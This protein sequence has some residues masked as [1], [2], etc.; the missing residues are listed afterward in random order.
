MMSGM[1]NPRGRPKETFAAYRRLMP[2]ASAV[3]VRERAIT[4]A[5]FRR[6]SLEFAR[7]ITGGHAFLYRFDWPAPALGGALRAIHGVDIPCLF[8]TFDAMAGLV[9]P[10]SQ[11]HHAGDLFRVAA[12][13]FAKTGAPA[14][15]DGPPWPAYDAADEPCMLVDDVCTL[16]RHVDAPFDAIW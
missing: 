4:D 11:R 13:C 7:A 2:G 15:P 12:V 16:V 6:P 3:R 10:I 8:Q 14:I 1:M 9:G 5:M